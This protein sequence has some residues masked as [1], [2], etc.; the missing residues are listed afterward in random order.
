MPDTFTVCVGAPA[1]FVVA[2]GPPST[3]LPLRW[4]IER[5]SIT[6]LLLMTLSTIFRAATAVSC[7]C[8]PLAL[9]LPSLETSDVSA[10]PVETSFT[11]AA[12]ESLTFSVMSL[13]P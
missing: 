10:W 8:P 6:P 7:T 3:I 2:V 9:S 1:T 11:V 12:I 13:S 4:P 5:A